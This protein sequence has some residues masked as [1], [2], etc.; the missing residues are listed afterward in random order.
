MYGHAGNDRIFI[1]G[2]FRGFVDCGPR[3]DTAYVDSKDRT[4]GCENLL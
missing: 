2:G 4:V 3:I 1:Q